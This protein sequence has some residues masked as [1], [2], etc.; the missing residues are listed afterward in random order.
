MKVIRKKKQLIEFQDFN[1]AWKVLIVGCLYT[2]CS[3]R[4]CPV[5]EDLFLYLFSSSY[6]L[7][8]LPRDGKIN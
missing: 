1:Y 4:L 8:H 2:Q 7:L 6:M 5:H 3:P